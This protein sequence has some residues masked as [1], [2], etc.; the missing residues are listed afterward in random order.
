MK[1]IRTSHFED[2]QAQYEGAAG[3]F[4]TETDPEKRLTS[5]TGK[6]IDKRDPLVTLTEDQSIREKEQF[7][8]QWIED[9]GKGLRQGYI[10][11]LSVSDTLPYLLM[12][13]R[14]DLMKK[15]VEDPHEGP[16]RWWWEFR[17]EEEPHRG[18]VG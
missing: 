16:D 13:V 11:P 7:Y 15:E 2:K 17:K 14:E 8:G 12:K 10:T 5:L 3:A 18:P 9:T 6:K 1:I 4:D